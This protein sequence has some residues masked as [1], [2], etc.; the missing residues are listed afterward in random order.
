LNGLTKVLGLHLPCPRNWASSAAKFLIPACAE[1]P[2]KRFSTRKGSS[3]QT[4]HSTPDKT[5][6]LSLFR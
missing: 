3:I 5:M 6:A 2:Q 4:S 1:I